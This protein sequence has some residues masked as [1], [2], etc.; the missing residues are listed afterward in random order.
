MLSL[1]SKIL[2]LMS[3][4]GISIQAIDFTYNTRP[5][6][7]DSLLSQP[8]ATHFTDGSFNM[9]A[10]HR[11]SRYIAGNFTEFIGSRPLLGNFISALKAELFTLTRV[12][13]ASCHSMCPSNRRLRVIFIKS[14]I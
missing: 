4:Y 8:E 5:D 1:Y 14:H 6:L 12:Q 11:I 2:T 10:G 7:Q 3:L 9:V 13:K